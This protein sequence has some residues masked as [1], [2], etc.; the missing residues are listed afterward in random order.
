[1]GARIKN[2]IQMITN[3]KINCNNSEPFDL[4]QDVVD[5]VF[6]PSNSCSVAQV[7][8]KIANSLSN[9]CNRKVIVPL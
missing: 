8:L 9:R 7:I 4:V 3:I 5:R 2:A 1:M 6:S